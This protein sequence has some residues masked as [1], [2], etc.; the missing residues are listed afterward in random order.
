M[1]TVLQQWHLLTDFAG[2][3][4]APANAIRYGFAARGN[5]RPRECG[6]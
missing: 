2:R 5:N 3:R 6:L 1:V 4:P